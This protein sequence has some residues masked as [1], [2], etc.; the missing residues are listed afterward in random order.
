MKQHSDAGERGFALLAVIVLLA[1]V[2]TAV[3]ISLDEAVGTIQ[4]G[5]RVRSA[6]MIKGGLDHGLN[7]ALDRIAVED[8]A[9]LV[10][11][12]NDWDIFDSPS[13]VGA[14]EYLGPLDYP[15]A[16]PYQDQYRVRVG[17]RPGQVA[18]APSGEDVKSSYGQIIEVQIS[19]EAVADG[20]PPSEERVSVGVLIP[21]KSG[22]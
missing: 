21:R 1:L 10:D 18:R 3:A 17:L 20:L 19:V 8:P 22:Y 9:S 13:A 11:P 5:G 14:N 6:E 4:S 16:G 15:P 2:S 12:N 7:E